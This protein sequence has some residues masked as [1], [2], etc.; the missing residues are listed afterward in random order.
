MS[1]TIFAVASIGFKT[2]DQ[3]ILSTAMALAKNRTP[4][5]DL[6][7]ALSGRKY[8][9]IL[10]VDAD[11]P[12]AVRRWG[13][14]LKRY[15]EG[16]VISTIM[17]CESIP[18]ANP[19]DTNHY[20]AKPLVATRLLSLLEETVID[21][22]GYAVPSIFEGESGSATDGQGD[23]T[24]AAGNAISALVVDDSLPVRIQMKKALQSIA[25]KI[26]FAESGEE[27]EALIKGN[28]YDIVFLDV[29]LPG[30]D[31]YDICKMIKQD[32]NKAETP[33]IMLT[34][35]SSPADKVK[36]KLA[37]CD[38]YMIKPVNPGIFKEVISEYLDIE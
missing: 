27:A 10:I 36:G 24:Q 14:Y 5:F 7:E 38:T 1:E 6:F 8:A 15:G 37:G 13:A 20:T 34:S 31:G 19:N 32:P 22:H 23:G 17:L 26:D 29:V 28:R 3:N 21:E 33:V 25:S 9:D 35:N 16:N 2:H 30:V 18:P 11:N 4:S 12:D